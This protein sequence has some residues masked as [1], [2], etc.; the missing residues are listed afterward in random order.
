MAEMYV[1]VYVTKVES[2]GWGDSPGPK[3]LGDD[4]SGNPTRIPQ[5]Q[6][7]SKEDV[8]MTTVKSEQDVTG[9]CGGR[10]GRQV[11][12]VNHVCD[13]CVLC[14]IWHSVWAPATLQTQRSG[15]AWPVHAA[16]CGTVLFL[17]KLF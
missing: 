15:G 8:V 7:D 1:C 9:Q 17:L 4:I 3:V 10:Q 6:Q 14:V 2:K 11:Q 5:Y 13:V 16:D 12:F